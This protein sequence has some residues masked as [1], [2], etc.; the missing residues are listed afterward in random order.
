MRSYLP[1]PWWCNLYFASVTFNFADFSRRTRMTCVCVWFLVLAF[2]KNSNEI[3][4]KTEQNRSIRI[5]HSTDFIYFFCIVAINFSVLNR[6]IKSPPKQRRQSC[7]LTLCVQCSI[8]ECFKMQSTCFTVS[9]F[10]CILL[11]INWCRATNHCTL[12]T[13][14]HKTN[15]ILRVY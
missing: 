1:N 6:N 11:K 10:R 7:R 3:D 4:A 2:K 13:H 5:F 9:G 8:D 12:H 14:T 15:P